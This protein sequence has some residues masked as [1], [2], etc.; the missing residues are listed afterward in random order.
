[1]VIGYDKQQKFKHMKKHILYIVCLLT[2]FSAFAEDNQ[3]H[4]ANQLYS[5][6]KYEEAIATYKEILDSGL[7]SGALY[8]NLGNAYYKQGKLPY[9]ILNYERAALLNPQNKDIRYNLEMANSQIID[10]LQTVDRFFLTSW[11]NSFK[12][13]MKSDTWAIISVIAFSLTIA[14]LIIYL[15]YSKRLIRQICFYLSI[16]LFAIAMV[17]LNFSI[18][19]KKL[20]TSDDSAIIF[21][22]SIPIKS[23]PSHSGKDLFI[24]H[25]G[26]KVTI[27]ETLGEWNRIEISD[28]NDGWIPSYAIEII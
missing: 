25:E 20:L 3:L 14:S 11:Y 9:A 13:A 15:F 24:L 5:E 18:K 8:Y 17:S 1:L 26:T 6:S 12:L 28:G 2:V 7:E 16:A 22:P 23:S 10:K 4:R 21:E 27:L 19:Q